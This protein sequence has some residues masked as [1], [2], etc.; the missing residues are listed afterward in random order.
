MKNRFCAML[1]VS[2]N[3]VLKVEKVK[4]FID[5]ISKMGYNA[6]MLY[7]EDTYEV[8]NEPLF[9]Y[10]RGAYTA[11]EIVNVPVGTTVYSLWDTFVPT[12]RF[13]HNVEG[14]ELLEKEVV[15]GELLE[16]KEQMITTAEG[17][18]FAGFYLDADMVTPFD[19]TKP[20]T[21]D[22][23]V[24]VKWEKPESEDTG[25]QPGEPDSQE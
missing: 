19:F 5:V 7:T 6:L 23:E 17:Y 2:R 24:Y 9:G 12:V 1:D 10:L 25:E 14:C 8:K 21:R 18:E 3:G 4:E 15:Y 22:T 11:S 13:I 20:I 16:V